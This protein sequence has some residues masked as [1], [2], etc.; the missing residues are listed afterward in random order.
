M[1]GSGI[2]PSLDRQDRQIRLIVGGVILLAVFL[3]LT[4]LAL[5]ARNHMPE[6]IV[7]SAQSGEER[8]KAYLAE[9]ERAS[10]YEVVRNQL[11]QK[12]NE[13]GIAAVYCRDSRHRWQDE[14][15]EFQG[16]VDFLDGNGK[17][18]KYTY[19]AILSGNS[20]KG[21]AMKSLQI[22]PRVDQIGR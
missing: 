19:I 8:L 18:D 15:I 20:Q 12:K 17:L 22:M 6:G 9:K 5:R 21:W 2:P 1:L 3:G 14:N 10:A 11:D 13:P 4:A 16:D 7:A